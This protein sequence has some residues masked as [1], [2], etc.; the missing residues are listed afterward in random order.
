MKQLNSSYRKY[1]FNAVLA[2]EIIYQNIHLNDVEYISFEEFKKLKKV[3]MLN[4][5]TNDP[6]LLKNN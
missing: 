5:E 2:S 3:S 1:Y 4:L 6:E